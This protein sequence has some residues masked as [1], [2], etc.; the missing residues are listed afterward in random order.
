MP[1][2]VV[3]IPSEASCVV[4]VLFDVLR[5]LAELSFCFGL[6]LCDVLMLFDELLFVA[7]V[8]ELL[9]ILMFFVV[10][11]LNILRLISLVM[12]TLFAVSM[13]YVVL[14]LVVILVNFIVL[15]LFNFSMPIVVFGF[16]VVLA[17]IDVLR[18]LDV[19]VL[20]AV[21]ALVL[22]LTLLN[23]VVP[24]AVL[25]LLE[26]MLLIV[27][28][29]FIP[30]LLFF[31]VL[32]LYGLLAQQLLRITVVV[33]LAAQIAAGRLGTSAVWQAI[34]SPSATAARLDSKAVF[35]TVGRASVPLVSRPGSILGFHPMLAPTAPLCSRTGG[36]TQSGSAPLPLARCSTPACLVLNLLLLTSLQYAVLGISR[37]F[38]RLVSKAS[39][40]APLSRV[41]G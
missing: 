40:G 20:F 39:L 23:V 38:A 31:D 5:F 6:R 34:R 28:L 18:L 11:T 8:V 27:C 10:L 9:G 4:L 21:S 37:C 36:L 7:L 35:P 30:V 13:F 22:V 33:V 15:I 1:F 12:L 41:R 19:L 2:D 24:F 26:I 29:L 17:L 32:V 16:C 14:M 25:M 3:R